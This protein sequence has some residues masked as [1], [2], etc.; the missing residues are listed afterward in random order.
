MHYQKVLAQSDST[1]TPE[2]FKYLTAHIAELNQAAA[3]ANSFAHDSAE[4]GRWSID[5]TKYVRAIRDGGSEGSVVGEALA[6]A[7]E[8]QIKRTLGMDVNISSRY[9]YYAARQVAGT[10][11]YDAGANIGDAIGVLKKL[12]TVEEKVWPYKAGEYEAQPPLG[13]ETAK[14]WQ[15][16]Q[17]RHLEGLNEIKSALA[18]DGPVVAGIQVYQEGMS[19][20]TAKTGVLQVPKKGSQSAGGHAVVLVAYDDQQKKFKFANNWGS[21]WGDRGYGYISDQYIKKYSFDCW[22]F[23]VVSKSDQ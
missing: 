4:T 21:G 22:S 1:K 16:K 15:I 19:S 8:I 20:Q 13:V 7:M 5:Y 3:A 6:T 23:K 10:L 18:T 14:R 2:L 17:V 12:G 9:I 11:N